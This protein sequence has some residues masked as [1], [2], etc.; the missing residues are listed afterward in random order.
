M[1]APTISI[2]QWTA[3]V[4]VVESGSYA[5]AAERLLEVKLFEIKGRKAV[6]T[7]T[8]QLLYRRGKTLVDDAERLERA[9]GEL[10]KGW[11][12]EIRLAVDILFP[13]WL[14]VQCLGAFS[15]ERPE[16]RIELYEI[17]RASCRERV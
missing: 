7:S 4:S 16:T 8:G 12:T 11:E 6:L 5:R 13:T 17:G 3:L 9:A 14:L 10:A 15:T 2:D 1:S